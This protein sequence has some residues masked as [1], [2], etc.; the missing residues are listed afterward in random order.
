MR[1]GLPKCII[2][3]G[4]DDKLSG[5][6]KEPICPMR[7]YDGIR[8]VA[9]KAVFRRKAALNLSKWH[10]DVFRKGPVAFVPS[11][12]RSESFLKTIY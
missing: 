4:C 3:E 9:Y 6:Q 12:A 7:R 10:F 2:P 5:F 11:R 1:R 8:S